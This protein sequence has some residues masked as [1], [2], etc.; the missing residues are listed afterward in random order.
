MLARLIQSGMG[1]PRTACTYG[2]L[3]LLSTC[4][5]INCNSVS[6]RHA[7]WYGVN[8][9][10]WCSGGFTQAA[11]IIFTLHVYAYCLNESFVSTHGTVS[12]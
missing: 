3:A 8:K 2:V 12:I 10:N 5:Y 7:E 6:R 11:D 4:V 9:T 1:I